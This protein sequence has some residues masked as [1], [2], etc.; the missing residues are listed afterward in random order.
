MYVIGNPTL[1]AG[2]SVGNTALVIPTVLLSLY[3][4]ISYIQPNICKKN[5]GIITEVWS[6]FNNFWTNIR[7]GD[8]VTGPVSLAWFIRPDCISALSA[9][10]NSPPPLAAPV[11]ICAIALDDFRYFLRCSSLWRRRPKVEVKR[12]SQETPILNFLF[13]PFPLHL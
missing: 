3:G 4:L 11:G 12:H 1:F 10:R 7:W 9:P 6:S 8:N 2:S 5:N 13:A